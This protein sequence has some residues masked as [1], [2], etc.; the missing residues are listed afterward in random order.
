MQVRILKIEEITR[1]TETKFYRVDLGIEWSGRSYCL[2]INY[3][4]RRPQRV[5]ASIQH[6]ALMIK[7]LDEQD[8]GFA[9]CIIELEHLKR[10]CVECQSL[11]LP[12]KK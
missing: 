6:S 7:L 5:E 2:S 8:L 11:A 4:P 1:E 3:L 10:G 9:T 12:P